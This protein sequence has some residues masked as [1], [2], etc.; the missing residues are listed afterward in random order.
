V[1]HLCVTTADLATER[2]LTTSPGTEWAFQ[3]S[4]WSN[5]GRQIAYY[6]NDV[7]DRPASTPG[8]D[9]AVIDVATGTERILTRGFAPDTIMPVWTPDDRHVL[10]ATEAA[11]GVVGA[12]ATGL[13]VFGTQGCAW[14][15]P[16]PDGLLVT[17]LT[18][19][20]VVLWPIAGG[21]PTVIELGGRAEFVNWQRLGR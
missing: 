20:Q 8:Y 2:M 4:S 9:V 11:P 1:L 10:F 16:S 21:P 5:D 18:G 14:F 13:R 17:C 15:E 7:V 6:V 12:D 3:R 19:N